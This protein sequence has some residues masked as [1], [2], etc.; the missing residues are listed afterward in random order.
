MSDWW[1]TTKATAPTAEAIPTVTMRCAA[2]NR[3]V[4]RASGMPVRAMRTCTAIS[5]SLPRQ[6]RPPQIAAASSRSAPMAAWTNRLTPTSVT[7]MM[8]VGMRE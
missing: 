2:S 5:T 3:A 7:P 1:K 8:L 4:I 6:A